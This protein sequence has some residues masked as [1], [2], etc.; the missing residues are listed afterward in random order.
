[1]THTET[2]TTA[3][4]YAYQ[5]VTTRNGREPRVAMRTNSRTAAER[6]ARRQEAANRPIDDSFRA[7]VVAT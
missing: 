5:V 1:M 3:R 7:E 4:D 2:A 6:K